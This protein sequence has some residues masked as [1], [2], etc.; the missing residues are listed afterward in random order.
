MA[1]KLVA[2]LFGSSLVASTFLGCGLPS[3][4][5]PIGGST[6]NNP[7]GYSKSIDGNL[8]GTWDLLNLATDTLKTPAYAT[9]TGSL[10][11]TSS[12]FNTL[13]NVTNTTSP[14]LVSTS[15]GLYTITPF[16][17]K[18]KIG[19]WYD[20]LSIEE[21]L[22]E[23]DYNIRDTLNGVYLLLRYSSAAPAVVNFSDYLNG[24]ILVT[25]YKKRS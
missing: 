21:Y 11:I 2:M 4:T 20:Y 12:A 25:A 18:G 9:S 1:N 13:N 5:N 23:Y 19:F 7:Y 17:N 6:T 14:W 15:N 22:G 8:V 3:P 10:Q 24:T 16:A